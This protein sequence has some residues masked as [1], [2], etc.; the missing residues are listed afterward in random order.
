MNDYDI[1]M[2]DEETKSVCDN[3]S[4]L[5]DNNV[6]GNHD[7]QS[8][9]ITEFETQSVDLFAGDNDAMDRLRNDSWLNL[10]RGTLEEFDLNLHNQ[11]FTQARNASFDQIQI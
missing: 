11:Q 8:A 7:L 5:R 6:M 3:M 1:Q 4:Y 9:Q 2:D 10:R